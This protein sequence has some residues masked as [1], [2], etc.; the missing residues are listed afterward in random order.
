MNKKKAGDVLLPSGQSSI[1]P[2]NS[3]SFGTPASAAAAHKALELWCD[4][5]PNLTGKERHRD[6]GSHGHT[7]IGRY[8]RSFLKSTQTLPLRGPAE[9]GSA[10]HFGGLLGPTHLHV[11]RLPGPAALGRIHGLALHPG[12]HH[13]AEGAAQRKAAHADAV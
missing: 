11:A 13:L 5:L 8:T 2:T 12:P 3:R 9:A 1:Q 6:T 7:P 10:E 4:R